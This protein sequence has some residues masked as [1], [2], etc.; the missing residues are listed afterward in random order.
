VTDFSKYPSVMFRAGDLIEDLQAR[1]DNLNDVAKRDL[2]RYYEAVQASTP[3]FPMQEA[4]LLCA[5]LNGVK[6]APDTL[7]VNIASAEEFE[8]WQDVDGAAL[9]ARLRGLSHMEAQSV[10]DAVERAWNAET[11]GNINLKRRCLLVGLVK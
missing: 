3:V 2:R 8:H 10:I 6:C 7:V 9:L 4:L 5:C 11:Y 1:G